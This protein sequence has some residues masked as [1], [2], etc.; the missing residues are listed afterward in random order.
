MNL[1]W[2]INQ[3]HSPTLP[4]PLEADFGWNR[5]TGMSLGLVSIEIGFT[6]SGSQVFVL[7]EVCDMWV[8]EGGGWMKGEDLHWE[9]PSPSNT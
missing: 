6:V 3:T 9:A 4:K 8:W 7:V 5:R 2:G 1:S